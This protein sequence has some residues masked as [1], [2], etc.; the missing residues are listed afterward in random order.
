M[1]ENIKNIFK[2]IIIFF[3]NPI[4]GIRTMPN[5]DL[6]SLIIVQIIVSVIAGCLSSLF[7]FSFFGFL[8]GLIIIP[9]VSL[10]TSGISTLYIY[11][12]FLFL[13]QKNLPPREVFSLV[14]MS[15]V[16]YFIFLSLSPLLPPITLL[17]FLFSAIL[18]TIGLVERFSFPKPTVIKVVGSLFIIYFLIW[19]WDRIDTF[20][21][22]K[23]I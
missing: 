18:L 8:H 4:Y 5:Y 15:F 23:R 7:N 3:K 9:F 22:T 1:I 19:I 21:L 10:I 6:K 16:P 2:T 13:Y 20:M 14:V 11:Y 12:S 17:G